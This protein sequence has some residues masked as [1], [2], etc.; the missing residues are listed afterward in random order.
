VTLFI[1]GIGLHALQLTTYCES[2]AI[3]TGRLRRPVAMAFPPTRYD[4]DTRPKD[5]QAPS[6]GCIQARPGEH[7]F[8]AT[9]IAN[10]R[11]QRMSEIRPSHNSG[12]TGQR[13]PSERLHLREDFR[14]YYRP[15]NYVNCAT[16]RACAVICV[17]TRWWEFIRTGRSEFTRKF[18]A[19]RL[20]LVLQPQH[21]QVSP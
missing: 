17:E 12:G 4:V 14:R 9:E 8:P 3:H 6:V 16:K 19:G 10:E 5:E 11:R 18:E 20:S 7:E 13:L 1:P 21:Y 15:S 2:V